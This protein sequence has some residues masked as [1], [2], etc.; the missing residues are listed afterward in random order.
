MDI[1]KIKQVKS[2]I[3]GLILQAKQKALKSGVSLNSP[4]VVKKINDVRNKL[5]K[6]FGITQE[7]Y[8]NVDNLASKEEISNKIKTKQQIKQDIKDALDE[9]NFRKDVS[10]KVAEHGINIAKLQKDIIAGNITLGKMDRGI[11][12]WKPFNQDEI[13]ELGISQIKGYVK[14]RKT[15]ENRLNEITA[16]GRQTHNTALSH[17]EIITNI[18]DRLK[19]LETTELVESHSD[20]KDIGPNDHHDELHTLESHLDSALMKKLLYATSP[21][22]G[23]SL[24]DGIQSGVVDIAG[25]TKNDADSYYGTIT[26]TFIIDGGG[27]A[28]T[29]GIKGDLEIPFACTIV[30]VTMLADATGS[31]VV[32]IWK[33]SY[34]NFPPLVGDSIVASAPPTIASDIKSQ[35]ET[36]TGWTTKLTAGDILRFN[37]NSAATIKRVTISLKVSRAVTYG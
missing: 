6:K 1:N 28:I 21:K 7:Q 20:L 37:V 23:K 27:Q 8:D 3:E 15:I 11:K 12:A 26:L 32:D 16:F 25:I 13:K 19:N 34:A 36:L 10:Q 14:D 30:G 5:L 4:L 2:E 35:D 18:T 22:F 24:M 9:E 31:I 33:D 29:T 17:E